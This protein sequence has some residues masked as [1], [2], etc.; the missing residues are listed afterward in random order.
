MARPKKVLKWVALAAVVAGGVAF[1]A[2]RRSASDAPV[3]FKTG[4]VDRGSV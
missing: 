4:K 3:V 2:L 1:F